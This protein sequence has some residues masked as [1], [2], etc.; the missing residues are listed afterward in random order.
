EGE[1]L[2]ARL[3][4]GPLP[5]TEALRVCAQVAEALAAAHR[6]GIVH[7]DVTTDNVMLTPVG[8]KVL[9]FG[10]ATTV[11]APDDDSEG[12]TFGT[13]A[14][15]APERLDGRR[16]RP[17]NDTYALGV[18]LYETLTG[19]P[20]F[21]A[22]TWEEL[23]EKPRG[24]PPRLQVAGLPEPVAD[25]CARSLAEDPQQRP[26]AHQVAW[27]LRRHL[28]GAG[29]RIHLG[30]LPR[31]L[32][33]AGVALALEVGLLLGATLLAIA[34]PHTPPAPG[35]P[36]APADDADGQLTGNPEVTLDT[37]RDIVA[38]GFARGD[39]SDHVALDLHQLI[40]NLQYEVENGEVELATGLA[41]LRD[42]VK[43][44]EREG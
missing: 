13:P 15:V 19:G 10:I 37:V 23:A 4:Q 41:E 6:H 34:P 29:R 26:T 11:G 14:Y 27:T 8:A 7:R 25:L 1:S 22:E 3:T 30:G 12:L 2:A 20:P 32:V 9:A 40:D 17:A 36:D 33:V 44:R 21:P 39:M 5:W 24:E 35:A 42:K 38:E 28:P 43:T 18:L 16:A 31:A